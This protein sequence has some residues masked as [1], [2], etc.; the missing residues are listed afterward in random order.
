MFPRL[1]LLLACATF[2]LTNLAPAEE[3]CCEKPVSRTAMLTGGKGA[4][5]TCDECEEGA[6]VESHRVRWTILSL[7][8]GG[9]AAAVGTLYVRRRK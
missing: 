8:L 6:P 2:A 7:G 4:P 3:S 9:A 1:P 5:T